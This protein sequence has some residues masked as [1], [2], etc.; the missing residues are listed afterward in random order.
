MKALWTNEVSEF[1][2]RYYDFPPLYCFPKP[3]QQPHPPVLLGGKARNV[4]KRIV[5]WGDG[6]IPIDVTP[7][8]IEAGRATLDRLA[9]V[10]G[11][12]HTALTISVVGVS[13]ER[14]VIE[15][16]ARA[17]ADRV[18]VGLEA[19]GE[20]ESLAELERTAAAVLG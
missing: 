18:I 3:A 19:A 17:G 7:Q 4:F 16:Y 20:T 15:Q 14:Q 5:A 6:W 11:R 10:A 8:E 2:G 13:A 9:R 1:H 12:D